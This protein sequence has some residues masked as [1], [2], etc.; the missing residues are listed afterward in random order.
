MTKWFAAAFLALGA[1][2]A[3]AQTAEM[4]SDTRGGMSEFSLNL[5]VAGSK[6][7]QFD[8]GAS[9]RSDGGPGF[10]LTVA[11]NLNDYFAVGAEFA[12]THF[13]YRAGVAPGSGNAG[14]GFESSGNLDVIALRLH[15][16]WNLLST[17]TTPFITGG[18]GVAFVNP[19]FDSNPPA[20]AC[21]IYPAYGQVCGA[22]APSSMLTR[23]TYSAG[24]GLRHDLPARRGF[25]RA[26]AGGE[27]IHFSE[28]A[29]DIGYWTLRVDFGLLF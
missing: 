1:L 22:S 27:W 28:A 2:P 5:L 18:A 7:Y 8:G 9:L 11:H 19:D 21:W 20:N 3:L 16:T 29:N 10:G 12:F 24:A 25:L 23:F 4:R 13:N 6:N 17:R 15:G 26:M 14:A